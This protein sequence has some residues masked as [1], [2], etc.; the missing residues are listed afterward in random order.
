MRGEEI[1]H[2]TRANMLTIARPLRQATIESQIAFVDIHLNALENGD[3]RL[4]IIHVT[5]NPVDTFITSQSELVDLF[6]ISLGSE[7]EYEWRLGRSHGRIRNRV[8]LVNMHL[9]HTPTEWF[10]HGSQTGLTL[11]VPEHM[12]DVVLQEMAIGDPA[13]VHLVN[14]MAFDD[15]T[16]YHLGVNLLDAE[17]QLDP[18]T[19][20]YQETLG[21]AFVAHAYR[22]YSNQS[23]TLARRQ[24]REAGLSMVQVERIRSFVREHPG[25]PLH[26]SD[27]AGYMGYTPYYLSRQFRRL[28]GEGLH[29]FLIR[30]RLEYARE[31]LLHTTLSVHEVAQ[32][33]GFE[34]AEMLAR[35]F[36]RRL[37]MSP[38]QIE[39]PRRLGG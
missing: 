37:G 10:W 1:G 12:R 9:A 24:Q 34:D 30:T 6:L 39:R 21:L 28:T 32:Q 31:L 7:S 20:F 38:R 18:A 11:R 3:E 25:Q 5:I 36:R 14:H 33:A 19:H 16:L 26:L 35:H 4:G 15:P 2:M 23:D 29:D 13:A 8:G 27:I 17:R 22:H